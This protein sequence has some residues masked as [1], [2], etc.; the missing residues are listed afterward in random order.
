MPP[1]KECLNQKRSCDTREPVCGL[2][3]QRSDC[4]YAEKT[5]RE[6]KCRLPQICRKD[7][8]EELSRTCKHPTYGMWICRHYEQDECM[9]SV[10]LKKLQRK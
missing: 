6:V 2:T 1:S 3:P 9:L 4:P 5:A 8:I 10:R 7:C